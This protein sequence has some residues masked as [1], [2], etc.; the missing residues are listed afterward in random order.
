MKRKNISCWLLL[1]V[2]ALLMG[3]CGESDKDVPPMPDLPSDVPTSV[4]SPTSLDASYSGSSQATLDMRKFAEFAAKVTNIRWQIYK[5]LTGNFDASKG[6]VG[7]YHA[8][9]WDRFFEVAYEL[10]ENADDYTEAMQNLVDEGILTQDATRGLPSITALG[11]ELKKINDALGTG[12]KKIM[13]VMRRPNMANT[14]QWEAAYNALPK[15]LHYGATDWKE[16]RSNVYNNDFGGGIFNNLHASRTYMYLCNENSSSE[17]KFADEANLMCAGVPGLTHV[18]QVGVP[19]VE[20]GRNINM[21]ILKAQNPIL[22]NFMDGMDIG[23]ASTSLAN[24]V[25]KGDAGSA[26]EAMLTI[27]NVIVGQMGNFA[28]SPYLLNE[29]INFSTELFSQTVLRDLNDAE[30]IYN[31]RPGSN[32]GLIQVSDEGNDGKPATI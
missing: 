28:D 15:E 4:P 23:M 18:Y 24:A 16:W 29:G 20:S 32:V 9:D 6:Y 26:R 10:Y 22:G 27:S 5:N 17:S 14:E 1:P 11:T 31:N 12:H 3:A 25:H 2:M 8:E 7:E 30:S 13:E 19:L 21:I